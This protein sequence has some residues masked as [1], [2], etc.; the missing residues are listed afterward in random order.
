VGGL[1][2]VVSDARFLSLLDGDH[3]RRHDRHAGQQ[4][5]AQFLIDVGRLAL[6]A[7]LELETPGAEGARNVSRTAFRE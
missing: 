7:R 2:T 3:H 6:A 4:V 5:R 1:L